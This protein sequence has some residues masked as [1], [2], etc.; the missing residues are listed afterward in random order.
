MLALDQRRRY[1]YHRGHT[2]MR[3]GFDSLAGLVREELE[4]NPLS[5]DV[6]IFFNRRKTHIKLLSWE[7]DG[8]C[9]YYKRLEKGTYELPI[10]KGTDKT[11]RPEVLQCVLGGISIRH[12]I[13]RKR[14]VHGTASV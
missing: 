1:F 10:E 8:F 13:L 2:D 9:V 11:I 12:L 5:G 7:Q 14:C 3:K 6:F 4:M